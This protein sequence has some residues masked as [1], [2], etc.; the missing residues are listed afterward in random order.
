MRRPVSMT[1]CCE[2]TATIVRVATETIC[3]RGTARA[4][5]VAAAA[6]A[7]AAAAVVAVAVAVR[8]EAHRSGIAEEIAA[9]RVG[10]AYA[11]A[12]GRGRRSGAARSSRSGLTGSDGATTKNGLN[13]FGARKD[14]VKL[15]KSLVK[16]SRSVMHEE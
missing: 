8:A 7:A 15:Q 2:A 9:L 1:S 16:V 4:A 3:H 5:A 14:P 10:H 12:H 6:A 13:A 11:R